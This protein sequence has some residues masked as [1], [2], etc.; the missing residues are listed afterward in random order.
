MSLITRLQDEADLCRNEGA[1]DIAALLD[2][3]ATA[4]R[5]QPYGRP[6]MEGYSAR[7]DEDAARYVSS[8]A[9]D[10][11]HVPEQQA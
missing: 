3:A 5:A 10:D 11:Q 8:T 2:E 4:L 1:D 7:R 9:C 6:Y